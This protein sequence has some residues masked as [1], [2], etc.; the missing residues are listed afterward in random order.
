MRQ[1]QL[2]FVF[3][4]ISSIAFGQT[5]KS[6]NAKDMQSLKDLTVK[7]GKY[8]NTHNMDS[9]GTLLA[10][11]VD[12]VNV[13]GRWLKGKK[14]TVAYHKERHKVVFKESTWTTDSVSI[15][16]V[17]PDLAIMHIV[18][19]ITGD[20]DPDGTARKPRH[21]IFSWVVIKNNDRWSILSVHNV[22][23]T[24]TR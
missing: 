5:A 13:A 23:I 4:V 10:D 20:V 3:S 15:K 21:G 2:V 16:Y 12:F 11:D 8:W 6:Y 22:N 14:E 19:G 1:L 7:W 18:W 17:K 9:M 24:F